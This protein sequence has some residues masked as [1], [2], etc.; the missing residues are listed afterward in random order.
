MRKEGERREREEKKGTG[1]ER[2]EDKGRREEREGGR[3]RGKWKVE[4]ETGE[5]E[6]LGLHSY[7]F[8][9]RL[10][11]NNSHHNIKYLF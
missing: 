11:L 8:S 5:R 6:E 2:R 1:T 7:Q 9:I 10:I 4:G 3:E